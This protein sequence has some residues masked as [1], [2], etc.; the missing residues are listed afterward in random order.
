MAQLTA[1][2]CF[3]HYASNGIPTDN[4]N[5]CGSRSSNRDKPVSDPT[6]S[7]AAFAEQVLRQPLWPHQIEAAESDAFIRVIAAARR[8]GKSTLAEAE[9]IWT[10]M[11]E[12]NVRVLLLSATQE[13]SRRLTEGIAATLNANPLTRGAVTDDYATRIKLTNDFGE[14]VRKARLAKGWTQE[15]LAA[16]SGL[17]SV[18]VSRIERGVREVRLTT[19]TRLLVALEVDPNELLAGVA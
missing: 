14:N 11:R 16:R 17:A 12:R 1:T 4:T 19:L 3:V 7:V 8:T 15:D 13:A 2:P 10:A 9:A 18:Q 5:H 6:V